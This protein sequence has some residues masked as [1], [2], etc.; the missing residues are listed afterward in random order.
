M[1]PRKKKY[2]EKPQI[3]QSG[4][5]PGVLPPYSEEA[6]NAIIAGMIYEQAELPNIFANCREEFFYISRNKFLFGII[7]KMYLEDKPI[8][9]VTIARACIE[10]GENKYFVNI[11][12]LGNYRGV[13]YNTAN[14]PYHIKIVHQHYIARDLI[15]IANDVKLKGFD[16]TTDAFELLN[17][18]QEQA[19][20]LTQSIFRK[21][22]VSFER[23]ALE[24]IV[25]LSKRM[26]SKKGVT[27]VPTG[28]YQLDELTSGWQKQALI[29]IGA[30]PAMGKTALALYFAITASKQG[31]PVAFFSLEMS[32]HELVFRLQSM[33]AEI[34]GEKIRSGRIQMDEF[35]QFKESSL[36]IKDL[37]LYI[38]DSANI[39]VLELKAKVLRMVQEHGIKL[40]IIDYLQLMNAGDGFSGNREQEISSIS[41]ACKGI[42]KEC[43][44]PVILLSQ[45]NRS[46]ETRG[47]GGSIPMLS[48][49]R[50]S[51]AIEQDAD[52]VIF[53]HRPEYY[54]DE[55]MTDGSTPSVDMAEIHVAKHRNGRLGAIMVRFE[56]AYTRFAP[57]TPF[58][59]Y[60]ATKP[61]PEP[62]TNYLP[63]QRLDFTDQDNTKAPF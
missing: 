8:D 10:S 59:T 1:A 17:Y 32:C 24:N 61:T 15:R 63:S 18:V 36:A 19:Y 44:I 46:V 34:E 5:M 40:L 3:D 31:F 62:K 22:A 45:L 2:E 43:D 47:K 52:M 53:P 28:F 13:L 55:L 30:R 21:H 7:Q 39:S 49:L 57:Y 14:L 60:E 38:D 58:R 42:A 23:L 54:K 56:K 11:V 12:E 29:V 51:G 41:R 20:N 48:D 4:F 26:D 16:P 27:G 50:E 9:L 25:E 6:E 33:E 37:P 35:H